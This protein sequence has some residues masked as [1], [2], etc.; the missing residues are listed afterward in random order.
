MPVIENT[1]G[2]RLRALRKAAGL[3][4]VNVAAQLGCATSAVT[5][6]ENGINGIRAETAAR[7]AELL[8]TTPQY[9]LYGD[10]D[11]L[12]GKT[13]TAIRHPGVA[14]STLANGKA[15]LEMSVTLPF[16]TALQ[17]LALIEE[18]SK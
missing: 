1:P 9:I 16:A 11:G 14:L 6:H 12:S 2:S 8:G 10:G 7:Y 5:N 15:R 17:I 18:A 13:A 3:S 4:A